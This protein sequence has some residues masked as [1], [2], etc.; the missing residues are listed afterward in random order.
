MVPFH[1]TAWYKLYGTT[2]AKS[3]DFD[4]GG[5]LRMKQYLNSFLGF[6]KK[7]KVCADYSAEDCEGRLDLVTAD[8]CAVRA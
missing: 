4:V 7:E 1:R 6:E 8:L 2:D 3:S 5:R